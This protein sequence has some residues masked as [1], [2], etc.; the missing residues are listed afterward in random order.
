[1]PDV[2]PRERFPVLCVCGIE[3]TLLCCIFLLLPPQG[4]PTSRPLSGVGA[5]LLAF[6]N[7]DGAPIGIHAMK[8][9][10]L[11]MR[12]AAIISMVLRTTVRQLKLQSVRLLTVRLHS[13]IKIPTSS[14]VWRHAAAL[15]AAAL[16]SGQHRTGAHEKSSRLFA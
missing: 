7:L 3:L 13:G 2:W 5:G 1:M 12:R 14:L 16:W 11:H 8:N 4:E 6:A 10:Q 9:E 15:P